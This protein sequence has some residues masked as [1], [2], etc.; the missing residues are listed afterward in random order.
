M[1]RID[2]KARKEASRYIEATAQ[3]ITSLPSA[4]YNLGDRVF[5]TKFGYGAVTSAEGEKLTIAFEKS[6][7]KKIMASFVVPAD[8]AG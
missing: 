3:E 1:S 8:Q 6:G 2:F 5:H 4:A 7:E